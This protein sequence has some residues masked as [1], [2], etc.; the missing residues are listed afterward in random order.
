MVLAGYLENV[1]YNNI[2]G[3][4]MFF[5]EFVPTQFLHSRSIIYQEMSWSVV[6]T[7]LILVGFILIS[8]C[9]KVRKNEIY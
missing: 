3:D 4:S 9:V 5:V 1:I 6:T 8:I 7:T 2:F